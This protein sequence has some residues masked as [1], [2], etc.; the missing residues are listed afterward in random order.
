M[1]YEGKAGALDNG[2]RQR[3]FC[4]MHYRKPVRPCGMRELNEE[5]RRIILREQIINP[6]HVHLFITAHPKWA[7][8][9]LVK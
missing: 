3:I 4:M 8:S 9:Q 2:G 5:K 7:Q 1:V 6:D